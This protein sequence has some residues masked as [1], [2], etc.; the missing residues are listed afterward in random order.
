MSIFLTIFLKNA[1]TGTFVRKKNGA[2]GLKFGMHIQLDCANNIEW[3]TSGHTYSSLCVRVQML[4]MVV[5]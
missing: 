1:K 4:E 2:T 5:L 3:V